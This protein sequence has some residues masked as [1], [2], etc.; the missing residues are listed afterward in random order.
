MMVVDTNTVAYFL[1][2]GEHTRR[3]EVA[4]SRDADWRVPS[5]FTY[6]WMNVLT[7]YVHREIFDR[8]QAVRLYR[9]GM[10][11]VSV[12][13]RMPDPVQVIN[14]HL[15]S[16]CSSYDCQFVALAENLRTNLTLDKELLAGFPDVAVDLSHL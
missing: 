16:G 2:E 14:L 11:L 5:L 6:E 8:D 3:A 10:A 4:R 15:G 13:P 12:E 1:I 7:R 9:R